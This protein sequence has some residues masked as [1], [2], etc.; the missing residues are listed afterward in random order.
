MDEPTVTIPLADYE[1]LIGLVELDDMFVICE[2]CGAWLHRDDP[3]TCSV[4]D[5]NGCWKVATRREKDQ[6]LCRS[7]RATVREFPRLT[8]SQ[9][10][11]DGTTSNTERS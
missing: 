10:R 9:G 5:F 6:H 2:V 4:D 11:D 7:Y 8:K 1:L 3:A